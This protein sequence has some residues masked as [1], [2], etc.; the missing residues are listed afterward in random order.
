MPAGNT[1]ANP[2]A[3]KSVASI[4]D[5]EFFK[6]FE[7]SKG[8]ATLVFP[9]ACTSS[10][11]SLVFLTD[12]STV[13]R[14][15]AAIS[16]ALVVKNL[17]FAAADTARLTSKKS[18]FLGSPV[19]EMLNPTPLRISLPVIGSVN[20]SPFKVQRP[21]ALSYWA[22]STPVGKLIGSVTSIC[23]L[24][25]VLADGLN[26]AVRPNVENIACPGFP[27]RSLPRLCCVLTSVE[28]RYAK[29]SISALTS[30]INE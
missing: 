22:D 27:L 19:T 17:I 2:E 16:C 15:D 5:N 7:T 21:L 25:D 11:A 30:S 20:P 4:G 26:S 12:A 14:P 8:S 3:T 1:L 13:D 6:T 24:T 18:P 29:L 28:I 10:M 23:T 9:S